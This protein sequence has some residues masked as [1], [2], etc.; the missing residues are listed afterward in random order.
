M[1]KYIHVKCY[2]SKGQFLVSMTIVFKCVWELTRGN[3]HRFYDPICERFLTSSCTSYTLKH[4]RKSASPEIITGLCT[5]YILGI[6]VLE[7]NC[8][9]LSKLSCWGAFLCHSTSCCRSVQ[10]G[11]VTSDKFRMN[12]TTY[13]MTYKMRLTA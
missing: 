1:Y 10:S 13:C 12:F 11:A 5:S 2:K 7:T 9:I 4:C 6:S 8:F 3:C